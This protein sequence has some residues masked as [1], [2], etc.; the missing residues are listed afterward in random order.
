MKLNPLLAL[1][2]RETGREN[3]FGDMTQI[4]YLAG[5]TSAL[6]ETVHQD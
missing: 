1:P 3:A 4:P 2:F 6:T 5:P